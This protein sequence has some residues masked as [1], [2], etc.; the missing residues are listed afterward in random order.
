MKAKIKSG[1]IEMKIVGQDIEDC[2][3]KF[4]HYCQKIEYPLS[5][6]I[7]IEVKTKNELKNRGLCKK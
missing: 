3:N 4:L 5:R 7:K 2:M 1:E 6:E